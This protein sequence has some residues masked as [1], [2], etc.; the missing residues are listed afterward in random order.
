MR[1]YLLDTDTCAFIM[2]GP[3]EVL[4]QRLLDAS[5]DDIFISSI[6]VAELQFGVEMSSA[7]HRAG[8]QRTLNAFLALFA[9][10]DWPVRAAKTYAHYRA[11]LHKRGQMIGGNDLFIAAHAGYEGWTVITNNVREFNRI[12]GLEVQNWTEPR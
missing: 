2:R 4:A 8:N 12:E 7:K 5:I 3:S 1:Q 10:R 6:T 9:S 11:A